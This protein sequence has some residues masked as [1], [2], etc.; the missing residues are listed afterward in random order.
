MGA[1]GCRSTACSICHAIV[2]DDTMYERIPELEDN[3]NDMPD[4]AI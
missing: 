2:V 3:G 1:A 4:L